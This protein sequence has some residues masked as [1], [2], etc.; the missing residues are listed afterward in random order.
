MKWQ[1]R[2]EGPD[3][4]LRELAEAL[5][6]RDPAISRVGAS[7]VLTSKSFEDLSDSSAVGNVADRIVE[8]LSGTSRV[9]L[10]S[11]G[12]LQVADVTQIRPNGSRSIFVQVAS[13]E[14]RLSGGLVSMQIRRGDGT[15]EGR[16]ASDPTSEWLRRALDGSTAAKALRIRDSGDL[17]W[18]TLYRLYEVIEAGVGGGAALVARGWTT[19]RAINRFK[20]TANSVAA[21]GDSARHGVERTSPPSE[22][23][24]LSDARSLID[25]LLA[26]WL[27][28]GEQPGR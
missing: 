15:I 24:P 9:L 26:A 18:S 6:G 8:A 7:Y 10:Q 19:K 16:R 5:E 12:R 25:G 4:V 14:Y 27:G 17:D 28:N 11:T 22:P 21:A 13:G 2:V 1:A 23:M 3:A 20:H